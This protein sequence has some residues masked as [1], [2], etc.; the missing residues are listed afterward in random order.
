MENQN[1]VVVLTSSENSFIEESNSN[2]DESTSSKG[3]EASNDSNTMYEEDLELSFEEEDEE[4]DHSNCIIN[5]NELI[6]ESSEQE[7][8]YAFTST[9]S[10]VIDD[11]ILKKRLN[12][13]LDI[14]SEDPVLVTAGRP[15]KI[16]KL[17]ES[18]ATNDDSREHKVN[19]IITTMIY[20]L[21]L[22]VNSWNQKGEN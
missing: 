20:E 1:Q 6:E 21:L 4:K 8:V 2:I 11:V 10:D 16:M 5:D 17:I 18:T 9:S 15:P 3:D 13:P 14:C 22:I 19:I 7:G 12:E